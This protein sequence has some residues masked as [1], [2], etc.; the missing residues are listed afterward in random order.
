MRQDR[1]TGAIFLGAA[2]LSLTFSS[3][4]FWQLLILCAGALS[5]LM[6][7]VFRKGAREVCLPLAGLA[8]A[9]A[10]STLRASL[11]ST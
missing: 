2:A 1:I 9:C 11:T 4:I 7:S 6:H 5:S 3:S 10:R 8:C